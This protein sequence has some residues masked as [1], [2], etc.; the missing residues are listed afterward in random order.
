MLP[1]FV[2]FIFDQEIQFSRPLSGGNIN[3]V[4]EIQTAQQAFVIKLN[5]STL[6]PSMLETE[7][8]GLAELARTGTIKTPVVVKQ[9]EMQGYQF[10]VLEKIQ[11]SEPTKKGW[12]QFGHDLAHLHQTTH[13]HFGLSHN[14]FI[15]SL[16][17]T[18]QHRAS[19]S[20]FY[21]NERLQPMIELA[22]NQGDVNYVEA[23]IFESLYPRLDGLIPK[24]KPSLIHGDLWHGNFLLDENHQP[25]LIDP[26]VYYGHREM[27]I[28]IMHLFGGFS[29]ELFE[30]YHDTYPLE[31]GWQER[32]ALHQLYP[33]LV[34][35]NLFGRSYWE[36]IK[37]AVDSYL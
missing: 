9:G 21:I 31:E 14:N 27:D 13:D 20:E 26:A 25:V 34:H 5:E 4:F 32:I 16:V 11:T 30:S 36:R 2:H 12:K 29:H 7:A 3:R 23:K 35:L 6:Y 1:D 10:L 22:V 18:N 33:L 17:Q 8:K 24:E 28:A 19:W 15:G 37:T